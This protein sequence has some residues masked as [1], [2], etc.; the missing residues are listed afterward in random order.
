MFGEK[1]ENIK[2]AIPNDM[3]LQKDTLGNEVIYHESY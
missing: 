3:N 1:K 2:N